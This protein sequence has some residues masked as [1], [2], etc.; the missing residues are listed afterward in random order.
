M[1]PSLINS[2]N[3]MVTR[4]NA[5]TAGLGLITAVAARVNRDGVSTDFGLGAA[6]TPDLFWL[7]QPTGASRATI[8]FS[9]N[10]AN[11]PG[12]TKVT[13]SPQDI[14]VVCP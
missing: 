1:D 11:I 14:P 6:L 10:L 2:I 8:A 9:I 12:V 3:G 5:G 7:Q 13:T 4:V